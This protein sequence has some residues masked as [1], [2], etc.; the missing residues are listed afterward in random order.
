MNEFF[1]YV[2][3]NWPI[4]LLG[5]FGGLSGAIIVTL[6]S[7]FICC[8]KREPE[9]KDFKSIF[10]RIAIIVLFTAMLTLLLVSFFAGESRLEISNGVV[11]IV[12]LMIFLL[13]YESIESFS[14]GNLL[15]LKKEVNDKKE[16]VK[17]LT[18][19][20]SELRTQMVSIVRASITNNNRA[21]VVL[22]F[23]DAF[24]KN[25][26]VQNASIEEIS[27]EKSIED[28]VSQD[29]SAVPER[30][31]PDN[32]QI[33]LNLR[34]RFKREIEDSIVEKF[35]KLEGINQDSVRK[36]VK[37]A[38]S[39]NCSDPI[40]I[41]RAVFDGYI[42]RPMEELFIKASFRVPYVNLLYQLYYTLSI[43]LQ[44]AKANNRSAK[45]LLIVPDICDKYSAYVYTSPHTL[46]NRQPDIDRLKDD[47]NPALQNGLLEIVHLSYSEEECEAI[48][49]R[50][51][52][53]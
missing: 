46:K 34:L 35:A 15:S 2:I 1:P 41:Y 26:R 37:F 39:E 31:N 17:K 52:Q 29:V 33:P 40:M 49:N 11:Y 8:K 44:Y 9:K 28:T 10:T 20:N 32:Y 42:K 36:N 14:I 43:I 19:E 51:S 23:G 27:E 24:L 30:A 7:H 6:I 45:L 16:Q 53:Q 21:E 48:I 18:T 5:L 22:G 47:F 4:L 38:A 3:K 12:G 13:I 25:V 50:I